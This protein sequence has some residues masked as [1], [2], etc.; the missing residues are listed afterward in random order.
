MNA[1]INAAMARSRTT[2][3]TLLLILVAGAVAYLDIPKEAEP[4]ISLP[5]VYVSVHLDGVSPE[6]AEGMLLGPLESELKGLNGLDEMRATA[7]QGGANIVLE[8]DAGLDID[9]IMQ[10]VQ[11]SVDRAKTEL[12]EDADDPSVTEINL[13]EFPVLVIT[14]SGDLPE[15]ALYQVARRLRSEIERLEGIIEARITGERREMV[16]IVVDPLTLDSHGL[17]TREMATL[18]RSNILVAAGILDTGNGRFPIKVPGLIETLNQVL[19]QPVRARGSAV[20]AVQDVAEV[21]S[22]FQ[23]RHNIAR[24]LGEPAVGLEVIKRTG[25]NIIDTVS[26]LRHVVDLAR[27]LLPDGVTVTLSQDRSADIR[28]MLA[29]LQNNVLTA[30]ILVM[31]LVVGTLGWRSGLMVGV[32]IPGSFLLTMLVLSLL[33]VTLNIVVLFSLILAVGMLVDAT[34]V[35]VEFADRKMA[36][37]HTRLQAYGEAARRMAWPITTSTATTLAVF[38]PLLFWPGTVGEFMKFLPITLI[39]V[40]S[41]SLLMAL[42]FVPTLGSRFG[43]PGTADP[44][45]MRALA[46]AE[47][48][49]LD[50]IGGPGAAYIALLRLALR[51]P[52]KVILLAVMALVGVQAL[53]AR[54]G[55]GIEFFPDVEPD[56][57]QVLVHARGSLSLEEKIRLVGEVEREIFKLDEFT[58]V[59]ASIG[60]TG[61]RETVAKDLIGKVQLEFKDWQERRPAREILRDITDRTAHLAGVRVTTIIQRT[62]PARGKPIQ[63]RLRGVDL[64]DIQRGVRL[65]REKMESIPGLTAVEDQ[66]DVPGIEW[67]LH[68]DRVLAKQY[69]IDVSLLGAY[70][71]M[72]TR[73]LKVTDYRPA[74]SD[75]EIDIVI[76][77]PDEYR[78]IS[79]FDK[80]RIQSARGLVPVANFIRWEPAPLVGTISRVDG[81]RAIKVEADVREGVLV[82][83]KVQ[84]IRRW[85][86]EEADLP[87]GV[88]VSFTGQDRQ[89]AR[90]T[91]FLIRAFGLAVFLMAIILVTQFNSFYSAFLIL[92]AV[93]MSTIGVMIG[94]LVTAQPFGVVMSGVGVI[95]LAGIVVN[96]NIVLIDTFDRMKLQTEDI[97]DAILR[98]GAQRLRPVLLTTVTT[99][100][101]LLPMVL[102]LNI[103]FVTRAVTVGG[104]STQWWVS[105]S[106]AIFFGL[107]F[108]SILTLVVTPC[109]LMLRENVMARIRR[110]PVT[111]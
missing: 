90:S 43:R 18:S 89:Q 97:R 26:R 88:T 66:L 14:L 16:E 98:T 93:I 101:G 28:R 77:Y 30:V 3:S 56:V 83:A 52:G 42:V 75:E 47:T 40:L 25:E 32:A 23:D 107:G 9:V 111:A 29:D 57:A 39:V 64:E 58:S 85:L 37:G 6:D 80:I 41:A 19:E 48:G 69:E 35:V 2:L 33:G 78:S 10:D 104:P 105:L 76:R 68:I 61:R 82:D 87:P 38:M 100:L 79:Q 65:V 54:V 63:V 17:T 31:V 36:E 13:S 15:R 22:T 4:D 95:A 44:R 21:R 7:Y 92:S 96:N 8:F 34:I 51:H 73:G 91:A 5:L 45:V 106:S 94:L 24:L 108:A 72:V 59:Y 1:V 103:D 81:S 67:R 20:I 53:Y 49:R 71:R 60:R 62:G 27:P 110:R 70:I 99:M 46:A 86:N 12:P 102:Q 84:E 55:H 74:D 11:D 50:E 109:A